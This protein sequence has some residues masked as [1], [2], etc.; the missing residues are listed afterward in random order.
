MKVFWAVIELVA[1]VMAIASLWINDFQLATYSMTF[2]I[3]SNL[4]KNE[5]ANEA[6]S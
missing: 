4:C 3:Y 5:K 6:T 1:C 2:A